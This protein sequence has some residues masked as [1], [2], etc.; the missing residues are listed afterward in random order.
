[1]SQSDDRAEIAAVIYRYS[2]AMDTNQWQLMDY[3]FTEDATADMGGFLFPV[4]RAHI[5]ATIRAAIEC[6]SLTHH[7]NRNID[8]AFDGDKARVTNRFQAWHKGKGETGNI[9]YEALGTYT[10]DFVRTPAGWRIK[11][12][13]ERNPIE[14]WGEMKPG[15]QEMFFAPAMGA[16][17]AAAKKPA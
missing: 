13:M 11:H 6:C 14:V 2:A 3:V 9:T 16:F 15:S 5:V 12:R 10:D 1:M 17:A 4:G 8:I 7:M